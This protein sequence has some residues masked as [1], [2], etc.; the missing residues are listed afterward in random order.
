MGNVDKARA[1]Y[2]S[3]D[4]SAIFTTISGNSKNLKL[5]SLKYGRAIEPGA[6]SAFLNAFKAK[7]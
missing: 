4:L 7:H 2:K 6:I 3:I 5:L 1:E